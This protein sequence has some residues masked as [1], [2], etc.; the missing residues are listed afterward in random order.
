MLRVVPKKNSKI[1]IGFTFASGNIHNFFGAHFEG[2]KECILR[3]QSL[4]VGLNRT[5]AKL[6]NVLAFMYSQLHAICSLQIS[7]RWLSPPYKLEK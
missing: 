7:P 1:I 3:T 4:A 2:Y 6:V 5:R